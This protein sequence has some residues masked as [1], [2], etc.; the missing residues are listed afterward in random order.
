MTWEVPG[1]GG[2]GKVHVSWRGLRRRQWQEGALKSKPDRE[3][4]APSTRDPE[5]GARWFRGSTQSAGQS[6]PLLPAPLS[7]SVLASVTKQEVAGRRGPEPRKV[8][9]CLA[10]L[11]D[12]SG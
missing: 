9:Q 1:G 12:R 8:S 3:G 10:T 5:K 2:G 4:P 6:A 11:K 7:S